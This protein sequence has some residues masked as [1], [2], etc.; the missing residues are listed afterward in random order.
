[1]RAC[2]PSSGE[3]SAGRQH[4]DVAGDLAE[5]EILHQHLAER[6]QRRLL[7]LAIHRRAGIDDVTQG[8]MVVSLRSRM[9][10]QHFQDRRHGEEVGDPMRLDQAERLRDVE[11]LGRQQDGRHAAR[12][13]H[14]MMHAR[15]VRERRHDQ[16]TSS[17][18]VPA[19]VGKMVHNHKGHLAVGQ[20]RRLR[21][22][23]GA[24]CEEEP[25]GSL[26]STAASSPFSSAFSAIASATSSRRKRRRRRT[27]R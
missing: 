1:M 3:C 7:I 6:L 13:L 9:L 8:G 16:G 18:V 4:G 23:R 5:P 2:G 22:A 25:A 24:R 26:S 27:T 20:Y 15:A 12:G 11:I 19:S 17:S 10:G 14:R 21:A